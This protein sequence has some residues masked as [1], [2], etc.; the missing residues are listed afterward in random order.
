MQKQSIGAPN[1]FWHV[2]THSIFC[3]SECLDCLNIKPGAE[4]SKLK[5][6]SLERSKQKRNF[7]K[8]KQ[9]YWKQT[10]KRTN[11]YIWYCLSWLSHILTHHSCIYLIPGKPTIIVGKTYGC[12]GIVV[13][14]R[15]WWVHSANINT[16]CSV[17]SSGRELHQEFERKLNFCKEAASSKPSTNLAWHAYSQNESSIWFTRLLHKPNAIKLKLN[18][19]AQLDH[20]NL[21]FALFTFWMHPVNCFCFSAQNLI[22]HSLLTLPTSNVKLFEIFWMGN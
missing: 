14:H 12:T 5:R 18:F 22:I 9:F 15:W 3:I 19:R 10:S 13:Y 8:T 1:W 7:F 20:S 4:A 2:Y 6:I 16:K 17:L 11:P 21:D